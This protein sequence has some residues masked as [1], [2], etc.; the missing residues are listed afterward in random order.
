MDLVAE[1]LE[2]FY[3][4]HLLIKSYERTSPL[5]FRIT[6]FPLTEDERAD[7]DFN[8]YNKY[9]ELPENAE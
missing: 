3:Q 9:V 6:F 2:E 1:S 5:Q 7:L 8:R 4:K